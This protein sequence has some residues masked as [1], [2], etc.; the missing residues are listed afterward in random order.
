ML[1]YKDIFIR[2]AGMIQLS[3]DDRKKIIS[4]FHP[5]LKAGIIAVA[6]TSI[7]EMEGMFAQEKTPLPSEFQ[8][9]VLPIAASGVADGYFFYLLSKQI[10][11]TTAHLSEKKTT[12]GVGDL[13]MKSYEKDKH[14]E[15]IGS[16]DPVIMSLLTSLYELR[17]NQ[18]VLQFPKLVH[19]PYELVEQINRLLRWGIV[20]GYILGCLEEELSHE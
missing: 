3:P 16:I 9:K 7:Q 12:V 1:D 2:T 20:Q 14:A 15:R 5:E 6:T 17:S 4:S 18:L 19:L 8:E 13:W 10:D 11:P